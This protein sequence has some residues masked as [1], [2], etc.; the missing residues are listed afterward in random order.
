MNEYI[1]LPKV[2]EWYSVSNTDCIFWIRI[3]AV[4]E[5]ERSVRY[6]NTPSTDC[7]ILADQWWESDGRIRKTGETIRFWSTTLSIYDEVKKLEDEEFQAML[8]LIQ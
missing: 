2:G 8:A 4:R 6:A 7:Q 5:K 3:V 1:G